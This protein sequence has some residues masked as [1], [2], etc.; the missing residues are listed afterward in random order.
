[1]IRLI[2]SD[3]ECKHCDCKGECTLFDCRCD[4]TGYCGVKGE[5]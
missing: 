5:E 2:E 3:H 4:E 1:M